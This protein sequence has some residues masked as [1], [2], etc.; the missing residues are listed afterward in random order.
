MRALKS[1]ARM[2]SSLLVLCS[3]PYRE[4]DNDELTSY[5]SPPRPVSSS[6]RFDELKRGNEL[7]SKAPQNYVRKRG[8]ALGE[9]QEKEAGH[10]A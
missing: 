1:I 4:R 3:L 10:A 6:T 9:K 7:T 8:F 5:I 2:V